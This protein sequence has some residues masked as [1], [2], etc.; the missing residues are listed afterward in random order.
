MSRQIEISIKFI[1]IKERNSEKSSCYVEVIND[2]GDGTYI[3]Y[4]LADTWVQVK[5]EYPTL[6][7]VLT[8]VGLVYEFDCEPKDFIIKAYSG[9][10]GLY[11]DVVVKAKKSRKKK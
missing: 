8:S 7:D 9:H 10:E 4:P 5:K 2:A 6:N 1:E 11:D 3:Y